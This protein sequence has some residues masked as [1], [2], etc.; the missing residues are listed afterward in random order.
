VD[1]KVNP[2]S[3]GDDLVKKLEELKVPRRGAPLKK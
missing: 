3:A 1:R 2:A